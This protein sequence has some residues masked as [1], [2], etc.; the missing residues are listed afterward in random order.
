MEYYFAP[1][2]RN[3]LHC[4]DPIHFVP[5]ATSQH[6]FPH[7]RGHCAASKKDTQALQ[8]LKEKQWNQSILDA[9]QWKEELWEES[10]E[11]SMEEFPLEE[12]SLE[13]EGEWVG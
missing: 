13:A 1:H 6:H 11:E 8:E 4:I 3:A 9:S 10:W 5:R 7:T 12:Y 2:T